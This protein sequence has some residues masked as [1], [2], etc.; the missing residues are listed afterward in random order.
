MDNKI[1]KRRLSDFLAYEW[2]LMIVISIVAIVVWELAYTIGA[3]RLTV[4][5]EFKF[6][7][8]QTIMG[9]TGELYD[10][11]KEKDTFSYDVLSLNSESLSA[12]YNV[13]STRLTVQEGDVLITDCKGI[14]VLPENPEDKP[15]EIRVKTMIDNYYGYSFEQ[16]LAD[17]QNYLLTTFMKDGSTVGVFTAYDESNIDE[18]K[19]E[20]VF[21]SR[22]KKD[23]RFRKESQIKDGI[24]LELGRVKKLYK[25]V[26]DFNKLL[27][28]KDNPEYDGLFFKYT[29]YEQILARLDKDS[30]EKEYWERAVQEEKDN[31]RE[32][33][34]YALNVEGLSKHSTTENSNPSKYFT[35]RGAEEATAKDVCLMVFNFRSYQP[36][37]Q[38]EC[39][40]FINTI[41]RDCSNILA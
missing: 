36:H 35:V 13:L 32:N 20:S 14:D 34:V 10:L 12:E 31:G 15:K 4:G 1:T 40:S 30:D 18:N 5:Q 2:I 17:G 39:I 7:Y 38:Y 6:Y 23:N 8:D 3:V 22:M 9:D 25:E 41:V 28:Y 21:R 29:K 33:L 26:I 27:G 24:Q 11:L 37:L 19:V 16:M